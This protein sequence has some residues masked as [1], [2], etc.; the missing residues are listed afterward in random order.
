MDSPS[1]VS[2]VCVY[3]SFLT[4]VNYNLFA[5]RDMSNTSLASDTAQNSVH[6]ACGRCSINICLGSKGTTMDRD[7]QEGQLAG[8]PRGSHGVAFLEY[9][10]W[11]RM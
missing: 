7:D 4:K 11:Y 2:I 5:C 10:S 1:Y 8:A 9:L 3:I 6:S